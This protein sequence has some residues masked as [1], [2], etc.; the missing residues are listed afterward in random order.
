[1]VKGT[2][3][4]TGGT[5]GIG[6]SCVERYALEGW[7]VFCVG[8]NNSRLSQ[9]ALWAKDR[10]LIVH[11]IAQDLSLLEAPTAIV[12]TLNS[13]VTCI[14][15]VI[16][17]AG[18]AMKGTIEEID[19]RDWEDIFRVN[20]TAAYGLIKETMGLLRRSHYP[21]IINISSIAGRTRSISL[22]CSYTA[23]K[24]AIIG[25]TRHLALELAESHI[26]VN[27]VCPSQT[28]TRMLDY[29]LDDLGQQQLAR[30]VPLGRLAVPQDIAD[31]IYFLSTSESRYVNG[32]IIDINGGLL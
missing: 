29:A 18:V 4:I 5:S 16:N 31:V 26:R 2:A 28:R 3:L 24:A 6:K 7:T 10:G 1:M 25:L 20:V 21:S 22:A 17:A 14:D 19:S 23:S 11:P 32:A 27:C 9:I 13:H 8:T 15:T 12:N 30:S